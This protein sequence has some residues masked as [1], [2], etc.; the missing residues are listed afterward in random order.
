MCKC[1][2]F[3]DD[4]ES[5]EDCGKGVREGECVAESFML[6][7]RM[8]KSE[9]NEVI[10]KYH[11]NRTHQPAPP[12]LMAIANAET[13]SIHLVTENYFHTLKAKI[14][15]TAKPAKLAS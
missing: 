10:T 4:V 3:G 9:N 6:A 11:F 5:D 7:E 8:L 12:S 13:V 1:Y 15:S 2:A 14:P